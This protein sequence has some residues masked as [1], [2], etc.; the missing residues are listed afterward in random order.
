M[1]KILLIIGLLILLSGIFLSA[2]Y[3]RLRPYIQSVRKILK[4]FRELGAIDN[5]PEENAPFTSRQKSNAKLVR[6]VSCGIWTPENKAV[7]RRK[8]IAYCSRECL[9]NAAE[10][11]TQKRR[12][13]L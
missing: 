2:V 4:N 10:S 9:E 8:N 1:L 11:I 12:S 7:M 6:C 5:N 3:L 13:S